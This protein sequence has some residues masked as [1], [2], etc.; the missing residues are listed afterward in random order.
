M[1]SLIAPQTTVNQNPRDLR[2]WGGERGHC[3]CM[4]V[5]M[6]VYVCLP[7]HT[8]YW[9]THFLRG[10]RFDQSAFFYSGHIGV[11]TSARY[12]TR[13]FFSLPQS[14]QSPPNL[15]DWLFSYFIP[16]HT[17][18]DART[19]KSL[20]RC[21]ECV[22]IN[23]EPVKLISTTSLWCRERDWR[24]ERHGDPKW[25]HNWELLSFSFSLP[26][27]G[28]AVPPMRQESVAYTHTHTHTHTLAFAQRESER[29]RERKRDF[30]D[31]QEI[32]IQ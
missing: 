9:K 25:K 12:S 22:V 29:E 24:Q 27:S 1:C 17:R 20:C 15:W 32:K 28:A 18:M 31:D 2:Y 21:A 6:W 13:F 23:R 4:C 19:Q 16:T 7:I 5:L 11:C 30:H 8:G 26:P 10:S 3:S 14:A